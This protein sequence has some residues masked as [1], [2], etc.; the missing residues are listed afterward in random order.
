LVPYPYVHQ[1]EN[2]DYLVRHGAAIKVADGAQPELLWPA[3]DGLLQDA[4]AL[5]QMR[6]A[7]QGVAR[8][9]AAK[10]MATLL[11]DIARSA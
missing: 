6:Q 11:C 7:M 8:P 10:T 1:D 5:Q 2:A 3:L 9:E 4:T